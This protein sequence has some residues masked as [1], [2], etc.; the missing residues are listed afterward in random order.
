M[1][2]ETAKPDKDPNVFKLKHVRGSYL[3]IFKK[4]AAKG[5]PEDSAKY[6]ATGIFD[7]T[8]E[9][10]K[11]QVAAIRKRIDELVTTELK[12][13][14]LPADKICLRDGS[15]KDA[16]GYGDGTFFLAASNNKKPKVFTQD[17]SPMDPDDPRMFSGV[18]VN[19]VV[20][21][22]A[23]NNDFGKRINASLEAVQYV[24]TGEA[25]GN[26]VDV[27]SVLDEEEDEEQ[28]ASLL[29]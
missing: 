7:M 15:E 5:Q 27:D 14:K 9:D 23:Q 8:N 4:K 21:L 16:N 28:G 11:A 22:W 29:G 24:R 18:Y 1:S 12:L 25:L 19:L 20:R 6:S 3:H 26:E 10:H 13:K 17:K 2:T